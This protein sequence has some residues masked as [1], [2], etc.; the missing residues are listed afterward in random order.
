MSAAGPF[1]GERLAQ[2]AFSVL[3]KNPKPSFRKREFCFDRVGR[4]SGYTVHHPHS[5]VS[6]TPSEPLNTTRQ[7]QQTQWLPQCPW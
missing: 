5:T 3:T 7:Q 6:T 1:P 4:D 2:S